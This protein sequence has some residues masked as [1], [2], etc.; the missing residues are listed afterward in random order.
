[1][2]EIQAQKIRVRGQA[3]AELSFATRGVHIAATAA[4][5]LACGVV[6]AMPGVAS[7]AS[8]VSYVGRVANVTASSST[9]VASTNLTVGPVGVQAGDAVLGSALFGSTTSLTGP[10]VITDAAAD[11]YRR[12]RCERRRIKRPVFTFSAIASAPLAAGSAMVFT[13]PGGRTLSMSD[14]ERVR[15]RWSG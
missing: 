15:D 5:V 7:T 2:D 6:V 13:F 9:R 14:R 3:E 12:S 11:R 1:M 10:V 4:S 8:G